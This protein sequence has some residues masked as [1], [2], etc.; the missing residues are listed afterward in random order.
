VSGGAVIVAIRHADGRLET[1]PPADTP[2]EVGDMII[3]MGSPAAVERLDRMFQPPR[4]FS[5][6]RGAIQE[7]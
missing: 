5:S 1:Q 3:A 7:I 6:I 2:L 4:G